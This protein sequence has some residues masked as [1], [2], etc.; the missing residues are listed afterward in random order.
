M[1]AE[2]RFRSIGEIARLTGLP[3]STI[4]FYERKSILKPQRSGTKRLYSPADLAALRFAARMRVAGFSLHA[5]RDVIVRQTTGDAD[6][7]RGIDGHVKKARAEIVKRQR[8]L[9]EIDRLIRCDCVDPAAC[10]R[11]TAEV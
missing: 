5:I 8:K 11:L 10:S 3:V 4:R 7:R 2:P 1:P 9:R 6:W